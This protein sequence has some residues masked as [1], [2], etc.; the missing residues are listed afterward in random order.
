MRS[1][2][3]LVVGTTTVDLY[4]TGMDRLP[5]AGSDEFTP[6]SYAFLEEPV[7]AALGGNGANCAVVL[8]ALGAHTA[9]CSI[10]G[11]DA[12]GELACGWLAEKGVR[13]EGLVLS[14][15]FATACTAIATDRAGRRLSLHHPG[16]SFHYSLKDLPQALL[17]RASALLLTSYPLLKAFR[18][19]G[20]R[21]A[22]GS[23]KA[24]GAVTALD[25][26][27]LVEPPPSV[28]ELAPLLPSV[29]YLMAN[30][31]ELSVLLP[32]QPL[33]RIWEALFERGL[34][35]L[36]VKRGSEGCSLIAAQGRLD[37]P[38]FPVQAGLTVGAGDSFDAA[39]LYGSLQGWESLRVLRF[40]SAAAAAVVA[41]RRG[42]CGCPTLDQIEA[43]LAR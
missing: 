1:P 30:E 5:S 26:G 15:E 36:V 29:D 40:A 22:L 25:I 35:N 41:S 28:E 34:E 24:A 31:R 32:G 3:Y 2:L 11:R 38:A 4:L 23:A 18:P 21:Q 33:E 42:P 8:A 43:L 9:L 37:C 16:G 12:F 10:V 19:E 20:H 13:L 14:G 39:F 7:S 27:P 17:T 6:S